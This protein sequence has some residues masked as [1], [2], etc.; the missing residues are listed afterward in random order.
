M[1]AVDA[2][3]V[4]AV[5]EGYGG[6]DSEKDTG[7]HFNFRP[8]RARELT[9]FLGTSALGT[10]NLVGGVERYN[11]F[12]LSNNY[13]SPTNLVLTGVVEARASLISRASATSGSAGS[14]KLTPRCT[15]STIAALTSGSAWPWI[16]AVMLFRQSMRSS[17]SMSVRRQPLPE[18][19]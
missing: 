10:H 13:Q 1:L 11:E 18:R 8:D 4:K 7:L 6:F 19:A 5:V 3:I 14:E 2:V 9:H 17:P 16:K 15:C 12:R